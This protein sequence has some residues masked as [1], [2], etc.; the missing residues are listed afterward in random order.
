MFYEIT[1]ANIAL[2][3]LGQDVGTS[4]AATLQVRLGAGPISI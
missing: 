3:K 4:A 1:A 2:P